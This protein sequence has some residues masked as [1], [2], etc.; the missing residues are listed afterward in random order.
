M[1]IHICICTRKIKAEDGCCMPRGQV[2]S[3]IPCPDIVS[4]TKTIL[5]LAMLL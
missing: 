1:Y 4:K 2:L 3:E 5:L